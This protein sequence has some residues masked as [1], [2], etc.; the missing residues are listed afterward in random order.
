MPRPHKLFSML[1]YDSLNLP[2]FGGS[3]SLA[4][5]EPDRIEP[6]F[7]LCP[8]PLNMYVN[9]L[10]AIRRVKEETIGSYAKY[11]WQRS[12]FTRSG[13]RKRAPCPKWTTE[14]G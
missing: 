13:A 6:K 8:V 1:V 7:C 10:V 11:G 4:L 12:Q 9:R 3:E 2:Q 14:S 5:R